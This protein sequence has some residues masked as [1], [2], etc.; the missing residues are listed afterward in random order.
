[1]IG[2][3]LFMLAPSAP[4]IVD[5]PNILSIAATSS[6]CTAVS[7]GSVSATDKDG[8]SMS[9]PSPS[10]GSNGSSFC[11]GTSLVSYNFSDSVSGLWS[12]CLFSVE[13]TGM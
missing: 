8:V 13:V 7:W 11:F 6:N 10:G 4:T 1:M 9:V 2:D 12:V 5:C 3:C